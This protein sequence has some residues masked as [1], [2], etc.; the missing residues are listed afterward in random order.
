MDYRLF[1]FSIEPMVKS[2]VS[3]PFSR[4]ISNLPSAPFPGDSEIAIS[5]L[6]LQVTDENQAWH[7]LEF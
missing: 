4:G 1:E 7:I 6:H 2:E 5:A 3:V